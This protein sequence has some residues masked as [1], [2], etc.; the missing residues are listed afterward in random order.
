ML[1]FD[2]APAAAGLSRI[3]DGTYTLH[4]TGALTDEASPAN[5]YAQPAAAPEMVL[6]TDPALTA[7]FAAARTI[8]MEASE[9]LN[10]ATVTDTSFPVT[11]PGGPLDL[12]VRAQGVE[13]VA[14]TAGSTTVTLTLREDARDGAAYTITPSTSISDADG[15]PNAYSGGPITITYSALAPTAVS[16][17]VLDRDRGTAAERE[18][19]FAPLTGAVRDPP[20]ASHA[21]EG[22]TIRLSITLDR[23]TDPASPPT[24]LFV[25]KAAGSEVT[26]ER[27][28][29]TDEWRAAYTV[30]SAAQNAGLADGPFTF[31]AMATAP[32]GTRATITHASIPSSAPPT[33]DRT[34][35]TLSAETSTVR[36]VTVE[37]SEPVS[38][39]VG[40]GDWRVNGAGTAVTPL[41]MSSGLE[42]E[43]R[44]DAADAFGTGDTPEV[45]Y[46][47]PTRPRAS[48]LLDA[49]GNAVAS[50]T[51]EASDGLPP[52]IS[53][54]FTGTATIT[55]RLS[56]PLDATT[57]VASSL[58]VSVPDGA[59]GITD[60]DGLP[61]AVTL[62][63]QHAIGY[64][65]GS[66]VLSIALGADATDG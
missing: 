45:S 21:R 12:A 18:A 38:G 40:A 35:P 61:D 11:G 34:V 16:Y 53:A 13:P 20:Y 60:S 23:A 51:V 63:A 49:A 27:F 4:A 52:E 30:E 54:A 33:I 56:E 47:M 32:G 62:A 31:E 2:I 6:D 55:L 66:L 22:D 48:L 3:P 65:A 25:G 15:T 50:A 1:E 9:P 37:F 43:L 14:Y 39:S 28:G 46:S 5:A 19:L 8:V 59:T 36:T 17:A 44:V 58:P 42:L 41:V 57:V 29:N 7:R 24:V 26:M 64:T 10:P